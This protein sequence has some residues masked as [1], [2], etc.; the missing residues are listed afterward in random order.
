MHQSDESHKEKQKKESSTH[1]MKH[2]TIHLAIHVKSKE[3]EHIQHCRFSMKPTKN[4]W[5][6]LKFNYTAAL[7]SSNR[8]PV[9]QHC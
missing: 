4:N 6:F 8:K 1:E 7:S 2:T 9:Y 3:P 5:N